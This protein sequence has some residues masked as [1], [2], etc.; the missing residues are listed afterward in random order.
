MVVVWT[1]GRGIEQARTVNPRTQ[2]FTSSEVPHSLIQKSDN[3]KSII[4]RKR[5]ES[6][7]LFEVIHWP[8]AFYIR[9]DKSIG[10]AAVF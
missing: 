8:A 3:G 10:S 9:V 7:H 6:T 5:N 1:I 2:A 4:E